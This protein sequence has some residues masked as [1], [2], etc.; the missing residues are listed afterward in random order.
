VKTIPEITTGIGAGIAHRCLPLAALVLVSVFAFAGCRGGPAGPAVGAG[1]H[2]IVCLTPSA[3]E[4]VAALGP[5]AIAQIVGVDRFSEYPDSVK[6]LPKIGEFLSPDVEGILTLRPDI[7]VL[8]AVQTPTRDKLQS[9]GIKVISIDMQALGDVQN[10]LGA[11]GA[12]LGLEQEAVAARSR[13]A[14]SLQAVAE[15]AAARRRGRPR[16]RVLV[17]ID[18]QPGGLGGLYAAGPG[19]FIDE[20]LTL[21]GA[22]NVLAHSPVRYSQLAVEYVIALAPDVIIDASPLGASAAADFAELSSVPAVQH[23]RVTALLEPTLQA[24]SPRAAVGA[25]RLL[26]LLWPSP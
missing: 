17:I 26:P 10:G 20:V 24:P 7:A 1:H 23:H 18:R 11:V 4:I 8:D 12:A 6:H 25:R 21:L 5:A 9:A 16:P 14:D 13:L 3:T 2:R 19:T 15:D 22:D